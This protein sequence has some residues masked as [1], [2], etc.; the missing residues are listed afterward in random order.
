M[1]KK[2]EN[3][4][5]NFAI[6]IRGL[7]DQEDVSDEKVYAAVDALEDLANDLEVQDSVKRGTGDDE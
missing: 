6:E 5:R 7:L 4:L 2:M 1:N 3:R